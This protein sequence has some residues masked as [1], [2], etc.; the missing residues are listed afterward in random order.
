MCFLFGPSFVVQYLVW[1]LVLQSFGWGSREL[2]ALLEIHFDVTWPLVFCVSSSHNHG[3]IWSESFL[4][5]FCTFFHR[6]EIQLF[7]F[8]Q[9]YFTAVKYS[10][11]KYAFYLINILLFFSLLC[12]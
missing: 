3:L 1:F 7:I 9:L 12:L 6:C 4:H 10:Y 5:S 11:I 2:V 8:S